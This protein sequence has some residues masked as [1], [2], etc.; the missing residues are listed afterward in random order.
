MCCFPSGVGLHIGASTIRNLMEVRR[1]DKC[2]ECGE[3]I[4]SAWIHKC[5]PFRNCL[6]DWIPPT[7]LNTGSGNEVSK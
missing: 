3:K 7:T 6:D 2:P 1:M 4:Q 5:N